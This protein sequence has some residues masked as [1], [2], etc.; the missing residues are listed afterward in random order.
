MGELVRYPRPLSRNGGL[1]LRGG[2]EGEDERGKG[3]DRGWKGR[4]GN[5]PK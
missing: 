1:F 2:K 3:G 5:N 4:E